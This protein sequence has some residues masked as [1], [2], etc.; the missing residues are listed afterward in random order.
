MLG[1][2]DVLSYA[3]GLEEEDVA[4][5]GGRPGE[6]AQKWCYFRSTVLDEDEKMEEEIS[7]VSSAI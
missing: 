3:D 4:C 1:G 5:P 6:R 2:L 7:D